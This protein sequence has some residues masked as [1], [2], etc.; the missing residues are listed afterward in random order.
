MRATR[1][2]ALAPA[3]ASCNGA[4]GATLEVNGGPSG[5]AS[6][7]TLRDQSEHQ[8]TDQVW[9]DPYKRLMS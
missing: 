1:P 4:A 9:V 6:L 5:G 8:Q 7:F 2:R 3:L